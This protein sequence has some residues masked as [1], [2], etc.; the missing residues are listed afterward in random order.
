VE[1][2]APRWLHRPTAAQNAALIERAAE[3]P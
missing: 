1:F 3:A 2:E